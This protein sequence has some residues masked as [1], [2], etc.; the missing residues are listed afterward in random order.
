MSENEKKIPSTEREL[1]DVFNAFSQGPEGKILKER[2]RWMRY[3]K[4]DGNGPGKDRNLERVLGLDANNLSHNWLTM[5]ETMAFVRE[6]TGLD[7]REKK[8]LILSALVHDF[9]EWE[10]GDINYND[11]TEK[12]EESELKGLRKILV[13]LGLNLNETDTKVV[14]ATV[15]HEKKLGSI[16]M[17]IE[18]MGYLRS[19]VSAFKRW[20]KG[21]D[22]KKAEWLFFDVFSHHINQVLV[23]IDEQ[24]NWG[25]ADLEKPITSFLSFHRKVISRFFAEF[26]N[27]KKKEDV[28]QNYSEGEKR[29]KMRE[30][31]NKSCDVWKA[32]EEIL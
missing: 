1:K 15:A 10:K 26:S 13:E 27:P 2:T 20:E 5:K 30:E 16:F 29:E 21:M 7:E 32:I 22:E 23:A 6:I 19:A 18:K 28:L 9:P 4:K 24:K 14:V 11:K 8:L 31:F 3:G 12:D 17:V 25:L